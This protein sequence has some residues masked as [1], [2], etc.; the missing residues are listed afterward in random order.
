MTAVENSGRP[1]SVGIVGAGQ[2]AR[3]CVQAAIPL[4]VEVSL[5]AASADDGAAQIARHVAV[6]AP[7]D[8]AALAALAANCDVLTFDHELVN[9][10]QL[11]ALERDGRVVRPSSQTVAI[12]QDKARQRALWQEAGLPAPEGRAVAGV[13]EMIAFG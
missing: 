2:L 4:G 12:A 10:D 1:P 11:R 3:M 8:T 7:D 6:A 9:V 13:D 5:L